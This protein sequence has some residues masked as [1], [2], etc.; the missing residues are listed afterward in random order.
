MFLNLLNEK[1]REDVMDLAI[2]VAMANDVIVASEGACLEQY[3]KELCIEKRKTNTTKCSFEEC[4]DNL[5]KTTSCKERKM[6]MLEMIALAYVDNICDEKE[7]NLLNKICD[8]FEISKPDMKEL[9]KCIE[10]IRKIYIEISE[11]IG[12]E[13]ELWV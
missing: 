8:K 6:I 12:K 4:I 3:Y 13:E 1:C 9:I 7:I 11:V 10:K 5:Y 2:Y